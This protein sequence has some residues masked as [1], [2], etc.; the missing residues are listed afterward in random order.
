MLGD[1]FIQGAIPLNAETGVYQPSLVLLSYIVASFASYVALS[2]AHQL[3]N[4]RNAREKQLTHWGGAFAMGAGIWAMH[5]IGMLAYKMRMLV[6]YDPFLTFISMLVAIAVAYGV[7]TIVSRDRLTVGQILIGAVLLGIG[8]CAMHYTG[9]AAMNMGAALRYDIGIFSASVLIA[10]AASGA[11]LW[12]AFTLARHGGRYRSVLQAGAALIMGAAICGMHYTGMAAAT[13]IPYADCRYDPNQNFDMLALAITGITSVILSIALALA[14]YHR[15]QN[16]RLEDAFPTR[17]LFMSVFLTIGT[18]I[19]LVWFNASSNKNLHAYIQ[20]NEAIVKL[21][22]A[23][24]IANGGMAHAL[25]MATASGE[26]KWEQD[27]KANATALNA[28]LKSLNTYSSWKEAQKKLAAVSRINGQ[29]QA[30]GEKSFLLL[31]QNK[32]HEATSLLNG[33]DYINAQAAFTD[34]LNTLGATI[35]KT[36]TDK[37]RAFSDS[38]NIATYTVIFIVSVLFVTWFFS[39]RNIRVWRQE[40]K[41]TR[42]GLISAKEAAEK[43]TTAKSDFLANM[44][45]EIRTP[46]NGVLGMTDLLLDTELNAEQRNWAEIIKKSGEGLLEIINDILDLS[47]IEAGKLTLETVDFDLY[48]AISEITDLLTPKTQEK[49][50]EL[51]VNLAPGLPQFVHG[52]PVRIR[53]VLLNLAS[54]AVKFTDRGHVLIQAGREDVDGQLRLRFEVE[55]TGVGIPADKLTHIFQ[56]FS[57]AEESTTRRFGGTG[58]GLTISSMLVRMMGGEISVRS[59]PGK[60]SIFI[61][62]VQLTFAKQAFMP[63]SEA[64]TCDL[65]GLHILVVDDNQSSREILYQYLYSWNIQCEVCSSAEEAMEKLKHASAEK[66]P[67][68]FVLVDYRLKGDSGKDLAGSVKA[69]GLLKDTILVMITA[70]GQVA[71]TAV[72]EEQGFSGFLT[73]PIYPDQLKAALQILWQTRQQ[74]KTIPMLTRHHIMSMMQTEKN[75]RD[76]DMKAAEFANVHVLVVEDMKVNLLLI[77]KILQKYGC[78]VSSALNGKEAV[79]MMRYNN[80][81]IVFMD[82]QMPE[83]DGF[84]ATRRIRE[85]ERA[86]SRPHTTIV[87]LTADAMTGDREKCLVSGMDDYLNKPLKTDQIAA[88]LKK[89]VGKESK[90]LKSA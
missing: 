70:F 4:A 17:L 55:D 18:V 48:A 44:S 58:L 68:R 77:T 13:F 16:M 25:Q 46:L 9:M 60:G 76:P 19:G 2:M 80:Y 84:E 7:L 87:A 33:P 37:R 56:K 36:A 71:S 1:F 14:L 61:F 75:K 66:Y 54:N 31:Q 65:S 52:D 42:T 50:I 47:K 45:H 23:L 62:E 6:E 27:Y 53:Q 73:K 69:A 90:V 72:L 10:I 20:E 88:T 21:N 24:G 59:E 82:C 89:W 79:E 35:E 81:G 78:I 86:T 85:E 3:I 41:T 15:Q 83:M 63:H 51:L 49:G 57:Q 11:A 12:I 43:A 34:A 38:S 74:G 32:P 28:S 26:P 29:M 64:L 8:I 40:L 67:Y 22:N 5:F 30:L 39:L